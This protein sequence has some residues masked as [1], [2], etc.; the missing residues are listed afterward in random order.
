V[1]SLRQARRLAGN[2]AAALLIGL[3]CATQPEPDR[4]VYVTQRAAEAPILD[5]LLDDPVW[6]SV[7]WTSDFVQREPADGEPPSQQTAFKVLYDDEALYFAV[8]AHDDPQLVNSML[9]RRDWFPG[10][11]I[12]VNIDSYLDRR[13]AFSFTLSLSG[14]RGDELISNDGRNWDRNWDPVWLRRRRGADLGPAGAAACVSRRR[15]FHLAVHSQG[16][17]RVGEPFR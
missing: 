14:T 3:G 4:R 12:E 11:W 13:T 16:C 5:G 6:E 15:A 8:R 9:A 7:A 17:R 1:I 2:G 10:D